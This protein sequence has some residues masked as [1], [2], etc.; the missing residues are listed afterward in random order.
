MYINMNLKIGD[1]VIRTIPFH[2]LTVYKEYKVLDIDLSGIKVINDNNEENWYHPTNFILKTEFKTTKEK[3]LKL[4]SDKPEY[5]LAYKALFPELFED[6]K[7]I[8]LLRPI[9][10]ENKE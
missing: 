10:K 9:D 7:Y 2:D 5:K 3:I 6:D 8:N 1:T 4:I